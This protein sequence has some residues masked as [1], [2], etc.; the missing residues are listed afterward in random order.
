MHTYRTNRDDIDDTPKVDYHLNLSAYHI[1]F[2]S[3][4]SAFTSK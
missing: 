4:A 3:R 1:L 2:V